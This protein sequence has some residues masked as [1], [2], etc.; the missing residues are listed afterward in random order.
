MELSTNS[1]KILGIFSLVMINVIAVDSLRA[2]P[3][4]A[5]Y[6]FSIVFFYILGGLLFLVPVAL[7]AAELATGWPKSGGIYVWVREAFGPQW[8]FLIMWLQWLY[9]IFWYPTI[10]SFIAATLAYLIDPQLA[11][12]K[13][14]IWCA[15]MIM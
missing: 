6:G 10:M 9:N 3:I 8:G 14:Y 15:V 5:E 1:K 13:L 11:N 2:V 12:D 4:G 7:I